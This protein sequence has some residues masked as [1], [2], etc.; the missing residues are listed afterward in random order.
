VAL[1]RDVVVELARLYGPDLEDGW[2]RSR[3]LQAVANSHPHLADEGISRTDLDRIQGA[4]DMAV[5]AAIMDVQTTDDGMTYTV[6]G[7]LVQNYDEMIKVLGLNTEEYIVQRGKG[8]TWTTTT[9]DG[10]Q[11]PNWH[12]EI[13]FERRPLVR[14][15]E[16]RFDLPELPRDPSPAPDGRRMA[17]Y[18]PDMQ[19]GYWWQD[20]YQYAKPLHDRYAIDVVLQIIQQYG[21]MITD[22]VFLGDQI[23][24]AECSDKFAA[25]M[26]WEMRDTVD[27][28]F[29]EMRYLLRRVRRAAPRA[30]IH[31]LQGN[32]DKRLVDYINRNAPAFRRL[33]SLP[34]I[35]RLDEVDAIFYPEYGE[36][37]RVTPHTDATHGD[38]HGTKS[39]DKHLATVTDRNLV[40]GHNHTITHN[41][42]RDRVTGKAVHCWS[43]GCLCDVGFGVVPAVAY[44]RDWEQGAL[45]EFYDD[46]GFS[47]VPLRI[48]DGR[49]MFGSDLYI[50]QNYSAD[51]A[52]WAQI[53]QLHKE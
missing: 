1:P 31:Y 21:D 22:V 50:G 23:D 33:F 29:L 13:T 36:T 41:F 48:E 49:G 10:R 15:T 39:A 51:V 53:P 27:M 47:F 32:H 24:A 35:L 18:I 5:G 42:K 43:G 30:R 12:R 26:P 11:Y 40:V 45:F 9:G 28:A 2:G 14:L 37:A 4:W 19:M 52:E 3:L 44:R 16:P 34:E 20:R 38:F 7:P 6:T 46:E 25:K 17:V 8:K